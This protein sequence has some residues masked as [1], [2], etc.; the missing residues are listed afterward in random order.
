MGTCGEEDF[1]RL[2]LMK[3]M[4][5]QGKAEILQT[6]KGFCHLKFPWATERRALLY[7]GLT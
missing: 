3:S 4:R 6:G 2:R 7:V 5:L 1:G